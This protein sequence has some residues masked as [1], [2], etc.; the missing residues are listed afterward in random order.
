MT[1]DISE[2]NQLA[3]EV[4]QIVKET[5]EFNQYV[6]DVTFIL[7]VSRLYFQTELA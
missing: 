1:E 6:K 4:E 7:Y 2:I 5:E 3:K